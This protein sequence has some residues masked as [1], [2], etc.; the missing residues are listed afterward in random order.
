MIARLR[1]LSLLLVAVLGW[2]LAA[3]GRSGVIPETLYTERSETHPTW[4]SASSALKADGTV[5]PDLFSP[6]DQRFIRRLL[7]SPQEGDCVPIGKL[8]EIRSRPD[9][10][11]DLASAVRDSDWVFLAKVTARAGGFSEG[12]PGT[13]IQV[14]PAKNLKGTGGKLPEYYVFMPAGT[15][16]VGGVKLCKT[17]PLYADLPEVGEDVLLLLDS[18]WVN[19]EEFLST[20]RDSGIITIHQRGGV[21]LPERYRQGEKAFNGR[22]REDVL[23]LIRKVVGENR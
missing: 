10:R 16:R 11:P 23:D 2:P 9:H 6:V 21:S 7:D 8:E 1:I 4:V 12:L 5:D 14:Q 18:S 15:F 3:A 13:L 22:T 17:H 20:G 19:G